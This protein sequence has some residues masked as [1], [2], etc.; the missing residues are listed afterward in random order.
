MTI[1]LDGSG[2][3]RGAKINTL[4]IA[5]NRLVER[6][7]RIYGKTLKLQ[8]QSG[9]E[10]FLTFQGLCLWGELEISI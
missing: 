7:Y 4:Q 3:M 6:L 1:V 2:S 10:F 9:E 8:V 5:F